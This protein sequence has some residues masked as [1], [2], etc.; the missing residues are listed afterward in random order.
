[1]LARNA[2]SAFL[3]GGRLLFLLPPISKNLKSAMIVLE[4]LKAYLEG[5]EH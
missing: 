1:M 3:A 5:Q 4:L 2:K